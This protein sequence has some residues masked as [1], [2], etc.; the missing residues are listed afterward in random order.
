L[1][2]FKLVNAGIKNK[3]MYSSIPHLFV[4]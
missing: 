4:E 1:K 2:T 3:P